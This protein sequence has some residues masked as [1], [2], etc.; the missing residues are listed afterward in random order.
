MFNSRRD[1]LAAAPAALVLKSAANISSGNPMHQ[2][3]GPPAAGRGNFY[4]LVKDWERIAA[5]LRKGI[6]ESPKICAIGIPNMV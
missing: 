1:A 2:S 5:K 3:T 4:L 6:R